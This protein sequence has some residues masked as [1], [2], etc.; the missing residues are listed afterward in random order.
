M[1]FF[2]RLFRKDEEGPTDIKENRAMYTRFK[3]VILQQKVN[4]S[5]HHV[6]SWKFYD[7][8]GT[9]KH[10]LVL[11]HPAGATAHC[12]FKLFNE[13]PL[14]GVRI[15]AVQSPAF[16]HHDQWLE[17]FRQFIIKIRLK[18]I[19]ILGAGL[20]GFLA[21]LFARLHPR[22]VLSTILINSFATNV[23]YLAN[24]QKFEYSPAYSLRNYISQR[25]EKEG[26]EFNGHEITHLSPQN[27]AAVEFVKEQM[28]D[29]SQ[30]DLYSSLCLLCTE[31]FVDKTKIS[32]TR[33]TI[34]QCQ[35]YSSVDESTRNTLQSYFPRA[36]YVP[37][38]TGGDFPY[39]SVPDEVSAIILGH[40]Q[41]VGEQLVEIVDDQDI[42]DARD[43]PSVGLKPAED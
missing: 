37:L 3:E 2:K 36:T 18:Q 23:S 14:K 38:Q 40:L 21:L 4:I 31:A 17:S 19:H 8:G 11:L 25:F 6:V 13:L 16:H 7:S 43:C 26:A 34:I 28:A 24:V 32:Q 15:I 39:I 35:D 12:F 5:H 30:E 10:P 20:G 41:R 42:V 9:S 22:R 27:V 33:M 29:L 1:S